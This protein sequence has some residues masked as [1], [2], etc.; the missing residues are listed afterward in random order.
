MIHRL[1]VLLISASLLSGLVLNP[2]PTFSQ[3]EPDSGSALVDTITVSLGANEI[4]LDAEANKIYATNFGTTISIVDG[5][6]KEVIQT[7][8]FEHAIT[9]LA[10][11]PNTD[12]LYVAH[13]GSI[14]FVNVLTGETDFMEL[15]DGAKKLAVNPNTNTLFAIGSV[16]SYA[17][18]GYTK[19][20]D[21]LGFDAVTD[22]AVN[23]KTNDVYVINYDHDTSRRPHLVYVLD[24]SSYTLKDRVEISS[25]A[26]VAVSE[27]TN[28]VYVASYNSDIYVLDGA[29][30][31]VVNKIESVCP[32]NYCIIDYIFADPTSD[33]AYALWTAEDDSVQVLTVISGELKE[34]V[35]DIQIAGGSAGVANAGAGLIY[36]GYADKLAV[37]D[38]SIANEG[39]PDVKDLVPIQVLTPSSSVLLDETPGI[40]AI[41]EKTD[42]LYISSPNGM[43]VMDQTS[44]QITE[45]TG[46]YCSHCGM[47]VNAQTGKI[48]RVSGDSIRV[49]DSGTYQAIKTISIDETWVPYDFED[50]GYYN[51]PKIASKELTGI[52][53]NPNTNTIYVSSYDGFIMEEGNENIYDS[54]GHSL[55]YVIDGA[56]DEIVD[57]IQTFAAQGDIAIDPSTNRVYVVGPESAIAVIDGFT[58]KVIQ[59]VSNESFIIPAFGEKSFVSRLDVENKRL[60]FT[61]SESID[62]GHLAIADISAGAK[63]TSTVD[64]VFNDIAVDSESNLVYL[65]K[66]KS[67]LIDVLDGSNNE[68][69]VSVALAGQPRSLL[70]DPDTNTLYASRG[71]NSPSI[72]SNAISIIDGTK[73]FSYVSDTALPDRDGMIDA[74]PQETGINSPENPEVQT[75]TESGTPA[76]SSETGTENI[77]GSEQTPPQSGCLIATAAYGSEF[78]P[79]VQMLREIRDGQLLK[80]ASGSAFMSAFNSFYYSWSPTVADWERQNP[81]FRESVKIAI[82]PLIST[83]SILTYV[84]MDSESE[85]LGYGIGV[86]LLNIGI[87]FVAPAFAIMFIRS[88]KRRE[89]Q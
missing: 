24:G 49:V 42:K 82:T 77:G 53:I 60:Y 8:E 30:S 11:N 65:L 66:S 26:L 84:S 81:A 1:L 55:V 83:L 29:S 28:R 87:Y 4:E 59:G 34:V 73:V 31:A 39:Y 46:P 41:N 35:N 18:N 56:T 17:I 6:T 12:T 79:Q 21:A 22:I 38:L 61:V 40:I 3:V 75:T 5:S 2:M 51:S 67:Y 71:Q 52:A 74:P 15:E 68:V 72:G 37:I 36:V 86:I 69:V 27:Q 88:R 78:A 44:K 20:I 10:F 48:Y 54:R 33:R 47:I 80:T 13:V 58:N 7:M 16:D 32:Y 14:S 62:E 50:E 19:T 45:P 43:F 57:T 23:P 64:G 25:P 70:F 89:N 76:S 63:I 85:A 9:D